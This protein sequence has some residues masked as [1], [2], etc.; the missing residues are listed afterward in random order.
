MEDLRFDEPGYLVLGD[1]EELRRN[2]EGMLAEER[3]R[4]TWAGIETI[5]SKCLGDDGVVAEGWVF[6]PPEELAVRVLWV[7]E[8]IAGASNGTGR[9]TGLL[10]AVGPF[11]RVTFGEALIEPGVEFRGVGNARGC[12]GEAGVGGTFGRSKH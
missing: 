11:V 8:E 3:R 2:F 7:G 1:A 9:H 4:T 10:E 5:D 6:E 12:G